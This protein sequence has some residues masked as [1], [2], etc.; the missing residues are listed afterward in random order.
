MQNLAFDD[1]GITA[2]NRLYQRHNVYLQWEEG[3][4]CYT[5]A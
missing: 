5:P 1:L 4:S 2:T 3:E